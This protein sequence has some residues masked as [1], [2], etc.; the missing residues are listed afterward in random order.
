MPKY[1]YDLPPHKVEHAHLKLRILRVDEKA[2]RVLNESRAAN[3]SK[4]FIPEAAG[5]LV[6]SRRGRQYYIVDGAHR[7]EAGK[8]RGIESLPCEIHHGLTV[9]QEAQLFLLKNREGT[10]PSAADEYKVGLTAELPI[11]VD[12]KAVLDDH[13]LEVASSPSA[14]QIA[15]ISGVISIVDRWGEDVLDRVLTIAEGAWGREARSWDGTLLGGLGR[16]IGLHGD[17]INDRQLMEKIMLKGGAATWLRTA[18]DGA[19]LAG[20]QHAGGGGRTAAMYRALVRVWNANRRS[21]RIK[22]DAA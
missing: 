7:N 10:K 19:T 2:Q 16:F 22:V 3:L 5:T 8:M 15:A 13:G 1:N 17:D 20:Q 21:G 18:I 11:Y 9:A 4:N 12:T 14:N 6:V